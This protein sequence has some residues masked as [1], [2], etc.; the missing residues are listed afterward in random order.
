MYGTRRSITGVAEVP[1]S[2]LQ[3][4]GAM[5]SRPARK[6]GAPTLGTGS[7]AHTAYP[8]GGLYPRTPLAPQIRVAI[9][10]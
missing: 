5:R 8:P 9:Q 1:I 10:F 4:S 7:R 6:F 3:K 2:K